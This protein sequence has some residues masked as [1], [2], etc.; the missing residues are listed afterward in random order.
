MDISVRSPPLALDATRHPEYGSDRRR[1]RVVHRFGDAVD[2]V[3]PKD[4]DAGHPYGG[5]TH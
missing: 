3:I 4:S 5:H 1:D 2:A